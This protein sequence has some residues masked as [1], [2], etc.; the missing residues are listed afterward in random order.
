MLKGTSGCGGGDHARPQGLSAR[1]EQKGGA[2]P[3]VHLERTREGVVFT[4]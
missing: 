2:C 4:Y 3:T 1:H